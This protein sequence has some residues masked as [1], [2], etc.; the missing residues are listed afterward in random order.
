M[1]IHGVSGGA[2]KRSAELPRTT[3]PSK[4]APVMSPGRAIG[5]GPRV[6]VR[7]SGVMIRMPRRSPDHHT[8]Q[9]WAKGTDSL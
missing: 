5:S 9:V 8:S 3:A 1:W 2:E 6:H 4:V 7:I